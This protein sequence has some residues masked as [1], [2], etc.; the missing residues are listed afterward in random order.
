MSADAGRARAR[1]LWVIALLSSAAAEAHAQSAGAL[2]SYNVDRTEVSVSGLSSGGFFASQLAIAFSAS[3]KGVGI[4]AGGTYD[5]A[6][7]SNYTACMYN[8]TPGIAQSIA[9]MK[10]WSGTRIDD[11]ANIANQ[12]IYLFSGTNDTTVGL[13][14]TDQVYQLYVGTGHFVAAA[15][16]K[17][18]NTNSAVHTFPTDFDASG[19]NACNV[20]ILPYISNCRFD[21]AGTALQWIYGQLNARNDGTLGGTL[22]RFD[23]TEFIASG[24]GMD[25]AGW[26]YLPAACAA[27]RQCRLHVALHGCLQGYSSI[28]ADFLNNTGYNR[29][30]DTNNIIVLYP[31]AVADNTAHATAA[32]GSLPN[33][34]GCWDWIGW[35]GTD[36][37]QKT[38]AQATAIMAMVDRIL[39]AQP[40]SGG[41]P[42]TP[43]NV[44]VTGTTSDSITLGWT[45][46]A[47]ATSYNVYRD[48]G[49]VQSTAAASFTDGGLAPATT[50]SYA[51]S[52][53]DAAGESPRSNPV[54]GTTSA[55]VPYS[56]KV[57]DTALG[58]YLAGRITAAQY[59]QL[60]QEYGY[61]TPFT[62]YLCGSTWTNSPTC[63]PLH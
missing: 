40:P 30:A 45:A 14:V 7:Q 6:R 44:A 3:F 33:P 23:Q 29:W 61:L 22:I 21:G 62:L 4:F 46:S 38:G 54:S 17:Y 18:D 20:S 59:V 31:Q 1:T 47:G 58:H 42:P 27:G 16:V 19:D 5:C 55:S 13:H 52:A 41:V 39:G 26:L 34:N 11:V 51:V 49:K 37:D 43:T 32:S 48:D 15:Q 53:V 2:A 35:Y 25:S 8:A 60:G 56:Q 9:N 63:G 28:G 10:N 36:F 24:H 12:R 50:H 57:T